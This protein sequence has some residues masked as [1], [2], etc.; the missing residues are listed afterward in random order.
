LKPSQ[1]TSEGR[2][3]G[4]GLHKVQSGELGQI[5]ALRV[6]ESIG[7]GLRIVRQEKLCA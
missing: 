5:L 6:L 4:C 1:A 3:Y 7:S 2:L